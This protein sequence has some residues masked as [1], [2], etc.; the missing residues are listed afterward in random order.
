[1]A[2]AF[3]SNLTVAEAL[4]VREAGVSPIAQVMGS[5][6]YRIGWQ[7]MPWGTRG[8][9]SS[10]QAGETFELETQTEAWNAGRSLALGRLHDEAV[11]AG[12][13]AVVGVRLR[14]GNY[15]WGGDLVEFIAV[16]TAVRLDRVELE[17]RPV[18]SHLSGQDFA[19][20]VRHGFWPVGIVAG[21][22]VA[23]VAA[24]WG[25]QSR[26]SGMFSGRQNQELPDYTR[27]LYDARALAMA[28]VTREAHGLHA[29]GVVGVT[30]ERRQ[31]QRERDVGGT[32]YT[33]L[34]LEMHVLGTAIVEVR[35]DA[36]TPETYIALPLQR[37]VS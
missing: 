35:H 37:E 28:R 18:L 7:A 3:S 27:G 2:G 22:T 17:D 20:L 10:L 11:A 31:S 12:A 25:Q 8:W 30:I 9:G 5:S 26:V 36:P 29:H 21:S 23:Y 33:D 14:R 15:E 24:G 6:V 16:G 32:T 34:I 4:V 1:M 13:D 19:K